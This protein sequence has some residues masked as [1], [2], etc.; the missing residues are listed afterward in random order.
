MAE[1]FQLFNKWI[2]K[3]V[4][5]GIVHRITEGYDFFIDKHLTTLLGKD[6]E[7]MT[8]IYNRNLHRIIL[9]RSFGTSGQMYVDIH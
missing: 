7:L 2:E 5:A 4:F 1:Y 3:G 8:D 6:Q 9:L